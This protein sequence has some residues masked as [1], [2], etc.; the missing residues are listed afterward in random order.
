MYQAVRG[1]ILAGR[2]APGEQ[3][4]TFAAMEQR[5]GVSRGVLRLAVAQLKKDGFLRAVDR[6]GLFVTNHPPHC[7]RYGLLL[8]D[9]PGDAFYSR[10]W[11]A[12]TQEAACISHD[13]SGVRFEV[14]HGVRPETDND[15]IRRLREDVA[16]HRLAGLIHAYGAAELAGEPPF[17]RADLAHSFL[18][19]SEPAHRPQ[20]SRD[21]RDYLDKALTWFAQRGRKRLAVVMTEPDVLDTDAVLRRKDRGKDR[22][23]DIEVRPQWIQKL[24]P[25][26]SRAAIRGLIPLLLD[27]PKR[28]RPDALLICDD[29]IVEDA[30]AGVLHAGLEVGRDIDVVAHCN[31]PW[32][33]PMVLPV[34]R[35]GYHARQVLA[36]AVEQIQQQNAGRKPHDRVLTPMFENEAQ[37][38]T[39]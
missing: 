37:A 32:P 13:D 28:Q 21:Y 30:L 29:N 19:P 18:T 27:Y 11:V 20:I 9:R 5:F 4:P 38:F 24:H 15:E 26:S 7:C 10:F 31:W 2:A 14:Y 35:L 22:S 17:D 36:F 25:H 16:H 12:L 33:A 3:L 8:P 39:Q 6:Q 34:Q 23:R 1:D